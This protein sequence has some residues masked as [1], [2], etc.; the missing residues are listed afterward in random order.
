MTQPKK[1]TPTDEQILVGTLIGSLAL[2]LVGAFFAGGL[3][4]VGWALLALGAVLF[5]FTVLAIAKS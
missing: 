1:R 3:S 4:F 2:T 5:A